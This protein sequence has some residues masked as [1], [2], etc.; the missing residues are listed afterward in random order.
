M[1]KI[2]NKK[3]VLKNLIIFLFFIVGLVLL[4]SYFYKNKIENTLVEDNKNNVE[5]TL[6]EDQERETTEFEYY[7]KSVN[8]ASNYFKENIK[9][10]SDIDAPV[11][12]MLY[13][14]QG[15]EDSYPSVQA[16]GYSL[17]ITSNDWDSNW[18]HSADEP[19]YYY[20]IKISKNG[21]LI[22]TQRYAD[23]GRPIEIYQIEY[24]GKSLVI[25]V[26]RSA[27]VNCC[28]ILRFFTFNKD[29]FVSDSVEIWYSGFYGNEN[30]FIKNNHLYFYF[31][32]TSFN[33]FPCCLG[34]LVLPFPV[35]YKVDD[36]GKFVF[37]N[38]EHK[39]IYSEM[40]SLI[41][42]DLK[43]L[44]ESDLE[45]EKT[46]SL[47]QLVYWLQA[48]IAS[49]N[50]NTWDRFKAYYDQFVGDDK[51]EENKEKIEKILPFYMKNI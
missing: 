10:E 43:L 4:I 13:D 15:D 39:E 1:T 51:Y 21:K 40:S 37:P 18:N 9:K 2:N 3:I 11:L 29:S 42:G 6:V 47:T 26:E 30:V 34:P 36:S 17:N 24:D 35:V 23:E 46:L 25:I 5:N 22:E 49:G 8:R 12:N 14:W 31:Y 38:I 20:E 27:G 48:N 41:E 50:E 44:S 45:P 16:N 32:N 28:R 19:P 33:Y 7:E